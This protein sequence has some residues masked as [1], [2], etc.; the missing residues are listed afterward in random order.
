[1]K[2]NMSISEI[3]EIC[4]VSTATISRV[5]NQ[6]GGYSKETATK[7]MDAIEKYGYTP[8]LVAKGL[9]TRKTPIIGVIVPDI[10]N[11]FY[12]KMVLDL[13]LELFRAGYLMMV[14]NVNESPELEKQQVQ[15]LLA[16]NISGLILISGRTRKIRLKDLPVI[17]IDRVPS[18]EEKE[19]YI[20]IESDNTMGGYMATREL[21]T[22]GCRRIAF[23]TDKIG[24]STKTKRY[25]GYC[26]AILEAG[27]FLD[28]SMTLRV[29]TVVIPEGNRIVKKAI[30][31]GLRF[32]GIVCSTDNMAIGAIQ[33]M[34]EM[35]LRIPE[36]VKVTGFDDVEL[37]SLVSPSVTTIHQYNDKMAV[38]AAEK[39][40]E[41]LAGNE[42][43]DKHILVPVD[44][45]V[46]ESSREKDV[47]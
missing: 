32:D 22:Q 46:R 40:I 16:Q 14:C 19:E 10:V 5:I 30:E 27:L 43:E 9:R 36:D 2:N 4:N 12:S 38:Y 37:S 1:M 24:E 7:V 3:A 25:E 41:L 26:K 39:M 18:E 34:K 45:I 20:V 17:Y 33:G 8:N 11:S 44:L 13:Q 21:I 23:M 35:G 47:E 42:V 15:A 29:D 28:P 6:K 31:E